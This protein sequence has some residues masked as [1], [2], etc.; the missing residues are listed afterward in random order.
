MYAGE[1]FYGN[2]GNHI[3]LYEASFRKRLSIGFE[4]PHYLQGS[5]DTL[6]HKFYLL[7]LNH[8][9]LDAQLA[10]HDFY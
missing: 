10:S 2:L 1:H 5:N 3:Y 4:K 8:L 6:R 9:R 7:Q